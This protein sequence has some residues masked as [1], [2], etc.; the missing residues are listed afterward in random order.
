MNVPK[1]PVPRQDM[2]RTAAP[3]RRPQSTSG[4]RPQAPVR[5][6]Q[7]PFNSHQRLGF[8]ILVFQLFLVYSRATE[9]LAMIGVTYIVLAISGVALVLA[10]MA[11]TL[12]RG[13]S[14]RPG[15]LWI[16]FTLWLFPA[17]LFSVWKGG[18]VE[19]LKEY[20]L[21]SHLYFVVVVAL[22]STVHECRKLMYTIGL[23]ALFVCTMMRVFAGAASGRLAFGEGL[24]GNPNAL[25][26]FLMMCAPC[27]ILM[28]MDTRKL[29]KVTGMLTSVLIVVLTFNT[30][31]RMGIL[32][33][34][35][36]FA[37]IFFKLSAF[38]KVFMVLGVSVGLVLAIAVAPPE[39]LQR[40]RLMFV[41]PSADEIDPNSEAGMAAGSSRA[42]RELFKK[43]IEFT[44]KNPLFGVGPG[45]FGVAAGDDADA[46]AKRL[47]WRETHNTFTQVSSEAGI[48][49][50]IFYGGVVVFCIRRM[51]SI[52]R[53]TRTRPEMKQASDVAYCLLLNVLIFIVGGSFGSAA[54][55][56]S[57]P[58][59]AAIVTA[60]DLA[61]RQEL[62]A[63]AAFARASASN[64][65]T[66]SPGRGPRDWSPSKLRG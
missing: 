45:M 15:F 57:F 5:A 20:W 55:T 38:Q 62:S 17:T 32:M 59:L 63:N 52:Y 48:P 13:L 10:G 50:L 33:L 43:S 22:T 35:A 42:R 44:L 53:Y 58:V 29:L 1:A 19:L 8:S 24:I 56:F 11:G 66:G 64:G 18:S 14:S 60:F 34:G 49:A 47:G 65:A 9:L 21:K 40:Y 54:Y 16:C 7:L 26:F 23:A 28:A 6:P 31:S 27:S 30:G 4:V 46:R 61:V 37:I 41:D 2:S 39:V 12:V 51:W 36:L 3:H 25:A